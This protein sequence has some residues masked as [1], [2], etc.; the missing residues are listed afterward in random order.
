[1]TDTLKTAAYLQ[2]M[3]QLQRI[4]YPSHQFIFCVLLELILTQLF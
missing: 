1:M 4:N 2:M 3:E